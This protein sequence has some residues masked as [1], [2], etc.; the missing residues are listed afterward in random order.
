MNFTVAASCHHRG[1]SALVS[2]VYI[3]PFFACII[4]P[5]SCFQDIFSSRL[6]HLFCPIGERGDR[7]CLEG[8]QRCVCQHLRHVLHPSLRPAPHGRHLWEQ[9][10]PLWLPLWRVHRSVFTPGS[11]LG[12]WRIWNKPLL[13]FGESKS[14]HTACKRIVNLSLQ[15]I[16]LDFFTTVGTSVFICFNI[17]E[18]CPS[19]LHLFCYFCPSPSPGIST[20]PP[21][22][23]LS[24][25]HGR[26][27]RVTCFSFTSSSSS[28]SSFS[29]SSGTLHVHIYRLKNMPVHWN[30]FSN[31]LQACT[32]GM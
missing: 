8:P 2:A 1:A 28:F 30:S 12:F 18:I 19:S 20:P 29:T 11:C 23:S 9:H 16:V 13:I 27:D 32:Y 24:L 15:W 22:L 4:Q 25:C 10:Q 6:L 3:A 21:S 7:L 31:L 5:A 17:P 14:M 26:D